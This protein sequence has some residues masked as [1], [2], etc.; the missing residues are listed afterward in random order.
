MGHNCLAVGG[1]RHVARLSESPQTRRVARRQ[2]ASTRSRRPRTGPSAAG[3]FCWAC[4]RRWASCPTARSC[5]R[6]TCRRPAASKGRA[7]PA[8]GY[9]LPPT[10]ETACPAICFCRPA[11]ARS[12]CPASWRCT[13]RPR[14]ARVSRPAWPTARTCTT[15]L[16]LAKRGY[17]VLVPDYPS[18]GD[19]KYDFNADKYISG[20]MKGIFNHMRAVDLLQSRPEVDP[21]RIGA[22][23]HS[24][25]GHNAMF[26]GVFDER[27]K[28][29]VSSCGWTPLHDY[30][31]GKL[32]GWTSDRYVPTIRDVYKLDPD[33]V[34]FDMYEIVAALAPR[35]FFSNSPLHDSN[36]DVAGVRKAI[37]EA[38]PI[39]ELLGAPEQLQVR[40]PDA[41]HEFPPAVRHEAYQFIDR[42]LEH[43][44]P[45]DF[46]AELPRIAPH[47]PARGAVDVQGRRRVSNRHWPPLSRWWPAP[48]R[49]TSTSAG[50][51]TSS[52]CA[53]TR[54]K[55]KSG[56]AA[57]ACWKTLTATAA[58]DRGD[59]FCR[60][61]VL[62]HGHRLLRRRR[63]R[64]CS[65]RHLLPEGHQW[66]RQGRRAKD[67]CT[68][69]S[70][71]VTCRACSTASTGR[72]TTAFTA[73]PAPAAGVSRDL[74]RRTSS[75]SIWAGAIFPSIPARCDLRPES[76][77][78]QHGMSFDDWGRKFVCSNSDHIQMV[79][80]EDRY[81]ARNPAVSA[82]TARR[83]H[84][85]RRRAGR[86]VP[87]QPGRAVADRADAAAR[88]RRRARPDRRRRACRRLLHRG[89]RH[90]DLSRRRL[91]G[92][93]SRS[94]VHRRRGQQ[95]RAS[96]DSRA[97]TA[98]VCIAR[99]A[100][101][102]SEFVASTDN[103]FRPAQFAN[104]PDG[105]LYIID[106]YREVIEHPL[107][108]PPEIKQHLDLTSGRDR[109]RIYRVVPNDFKQPPRPRLGE[110]SPV[111]L[112][113]QLESRNGWTRDTASRLLFERQDRAAVDPLE[114]LAANSKLPEGADAR[115]VRVGGAERAV[116]G[117]GAGA[118]RRRASS[119]SRTCG[120]LGRAFGRRA[121]RF[122]SQA[123]RDGQRPRRAGSLSGRL[124]AGRV[125]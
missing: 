47:E 7:S 101:E 111:E 53:T 33:S 41:G 113:A 109:G 72:S 74:M 49:S 90:H 2:R 56:W 3:T 77:G 87:H 60:G 4:S 125:R 100:D 9:R 39:Y 32:E 81:V 26:V 57:C 89:H 11:A 1:R 31:G 69:A 118:T 123:H 16:E 116:A 22:I 44:P 124:F 76:G 97:A 117:R 34:P 75:R 64:R 37:A 68:P 120:A 80:F 93:V 27:I 105:A 45:N 38:K 14:R 19:Y 6:S 110:L 58:I 13:R 24:L 59:D 114:R 82:P 28:V 21:A 5:H 112:V 91:A 86:G 66:R 20:S 103:W 106:V 84:R 55:T 36:F 71:A 115:A 17:V 52:R 79:M 92:R 67:S 94:I 48:W 61:A 99:R 51:C 35:G 62:A 104:G 122:A 54:S 50:G 42:I 73:P 96:Q 15:A 18:F 108:L 88:D 98:S 107:S 8:S 30:Y 29:I 63:F 65:S 10:R 121:C 70:R 78:A 119:G 43:T 23:G 40:Y 46:K 25:G 85:G 102:G 95:Y 83:E 12:A